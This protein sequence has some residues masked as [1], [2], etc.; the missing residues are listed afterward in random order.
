MVVVT[1]I[2]LLAAMAL[3]TYRHITLRSKATAVV[4]DMRAFSGVFLNYN[5]S[6]GAWPVSA[7][8]G[9][10]PTEVADAI[11][12]GFTKQ[13]PIGGYYQWDNANSGNG[14]HVTAA[15][16][17]ATAN[18][19]AVSDDLELLELVDRLMDDGD[20]NTGNVRLGSTNNLV[21]IIEP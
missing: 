14:F 16:S 21:Y 13:S 18:S 5:L 2:G 4:T 1:L 19:S 9:V 3:P 8:P 15:I 6:K 10:V 20:L 7:A 17:I 12:S 11:Q